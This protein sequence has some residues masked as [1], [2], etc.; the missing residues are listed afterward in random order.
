ML[1]YIFIIFFII[2]SSS[3][4]FCTLPPHFIDLSS[5]SPT[6]FYLILFFLTSFSPNISPTQHFPSEFPRGPHNVTKCIPSY[7]PRTFPSVFLA[8]ENILFTGTV[9]GK[10]FTLLYIYIYMLVGK[11]LPYFEDCGYIGTIFIY[12]YIIYS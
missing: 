5:F 10:I 7:F 4:I 8:M 12:I 2:H 3:Y 1:S 6:H 11:M 9:S